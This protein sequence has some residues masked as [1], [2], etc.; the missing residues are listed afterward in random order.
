MATEDKF[1]KGVVYTTGID[2]NAEKPLDSRYVVAKFADLAEHVNS[3]RAYAGMLVY[4]E[5]D[6][7]TYQ[8]GSD[9]T[10]K[11]L[12][13]KV[14]DSLTSTST[15]EALSANQGR[16][17]KE[18]IDAEVSGAYTAKGSASVEEIN[19]FTAEELANGDVYNVTDTGTITLGDVQ[20][21]AGDNVVYITAPEP[22][23]DRLVGAN[24]KLIIT[25]KDSSGQETSILEYNGSAEK[26]LEL[27]AIASSSIDAL[28]I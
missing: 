9:N 21:N 27:N 1:G 26:K 13:T 22:H 12:P 3:H 24:Q 4:C 23:W 25:G 15:D 11:V 10:W 18:L 17:L 19:A 7:L 20:V 28:F 2:L 16:V 6:G 14:T 8:L 5:E